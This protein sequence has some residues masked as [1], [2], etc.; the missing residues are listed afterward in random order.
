MLN[1]V[2]RGFSDEN[3]SVSCAS[4][5]RTGNKAGIKI[6]GIFILI[7]SMRFNKYVILNKGHVRN[8]SIQSRDGIQKKKN[9]E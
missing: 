8:F 1:Y 4:V 5:K 9:R 7:F 3:Y 6:E 2:F